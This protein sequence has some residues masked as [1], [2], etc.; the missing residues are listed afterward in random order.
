[1]IDGNKIGDH[2]S[3]EG[4]TLLCGVRK[5]RRKTDRRMRNSSILS[6]YKWPHT[7]D[8]SYIMFKNDH[9]MFTNL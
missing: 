8:P 9:S 4:Y 3:L 7:D 1:M 2:E 6:G 5:N